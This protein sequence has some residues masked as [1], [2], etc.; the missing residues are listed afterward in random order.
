MDND[1]RSNKAWDIFWKITSRPKLILAI[2]FIIIIATAAF[3]PTLTIDSRSESFLP[4]D[5][6][7]LLYRDHVEDIFGL[8][9]PMV[10]AVV[11]HGEHGVFNP[12]SLQLVQW[13]TDEVMKIPDI[14]QDRVVSLATEDNI[15]GDEAGMLVDPFF[16]APPQTQKQAD[17]VRQ[18]VMN[19]PLY[20]G[21]LVARDGTATLI[22]TEVYDVNN[23]P[24]VYEELM[25]LVKRASVNGEQLHVAGDGAV[26]G[27][28][29][30][31]INADAA[32]L[33]PIS[34]IIIT[35]LS[36]LAFRTWRG[37][38][39]PGI[40]IFS[41]VAAAMG[42][43]A[44]FHVPVYVITTSM[45]VLLVA[46]AVADSIHILSQYYEELA[47]HP[48]HSQRDLVVRTMVLMW[49]PVT[50]TT[51]TSMVGFLGI[52]ISSFMPPMQAFGIYSMIGLGMA[53]LFSL[54]FVPAAL[55]LLKPL[56]SP[57]F[58]TRNHQLEQ[59]FF[60]RQMDKVG[61]WVLVN[62]K[63]ILFSAIIIF[64][65]GVFGALQLEVNESWVE[66]FRK[67]DPI[68]L[69]DKA[70]N[71]TMD[72]S[73]TLDIVI[74]TPHKEDLFKPDN[75]HRIEKLQRFLVTLPHVNG[76]T[77]IVDYIK[78]MNRSLNN[79]DPASYVI[80]SDADLISQYFLLYSASGDPTDFEEEIDYDY[81]MALVRARMDSARYQ[82]DKLV[83]E[84]TQKYIDEIF[85]TPDIKASL[86]GRVNVDYEWLDSLLGTQFKSV[87]FALILV[88]ILVCLSLRSFYGGTLALIPVLL[89]SL[90]VYAFMGISGITLA[91]GTTMTAAIAL[92]IGIDFSIHTLDRIKLLIL[93]QGLN[94]DQ[95]LIQIYRTTGRALLFSFFAVFIGFGILG[96]SYVPALSKLGVL[97]AFAVL[98]SF[99]SS[100]TVLPALIKHLRPKFLGYTS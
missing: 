94:T 80:P 48:E 38:I 21:S 11:N 74:E 41:S 69:A 13:L 66:N 97:I 57:A 14:N 98:I 43:M 6:P 47:E 32:R 58:K 65:L 73:N 8:K 39:I 20:Q 29:V 100:M 56:H 79:N 23:A 35:L 19:F 24:K 18:A 25:R 15:T 40:V 10:I 72:G 52:T 82:Q 2:S 54:G 83:V 55:V 3:I 12:H 77:S 30:S 87:L 63:K 31:Y 90:S 42:L 75:L 46:I 51:L 9:D 91:V 85:N 1:Y 4:D 67:G 33:V 68:Y 95:A 60:S 26:S 93:E 81:Q 17:K 36:V 50:I 53:G 5:D 7:A 88:W 62:T 78:Q 86:S 84:A 76:S 70:I 22:V 37:T 64:V 34:V 61:A 92:G 49:R 28:L 59:D 45:P 44:A 16:E 89:G 71:H 96:L 27:Y 99:I